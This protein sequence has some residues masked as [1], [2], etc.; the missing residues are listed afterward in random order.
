M[1][2]LAIAVALSAFAGGCALTCTEMGCNGTYA[3]SFEADSWDDGDY[4]LS[5]D[6]DGMGAEECAFSLPADGEQAC[7]SFTAITVED[8][9]LSIAVRTPMN[10]DLIEADVELSIGDTVLFAE[11]VEPAWGEPFWPNG[12]ACDRGYGCLSAEDAFSL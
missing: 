2:R 9:V 6:F 8:G 4:V 7:D 1:T 12:K 10:E 5:V 3:L 11:L